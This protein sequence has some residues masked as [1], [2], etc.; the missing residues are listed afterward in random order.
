MA[1]ADVAE[2]LMP[3]VANEDI[4]TSLER[5]IQALRSL[6]EAAQTKAES[7]GEESTKEENAAD[8]ELKGNTADA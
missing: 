1:P 8:E 3:K 4:E 5:L 2:N 7:N 6:K